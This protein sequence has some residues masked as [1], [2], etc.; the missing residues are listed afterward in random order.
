MQ[1]RSIKYQNKKQKTASQLK[2]RNKIYLFTKKSQ[3]KKVKQ[4]IELC[5]SRIVSCQED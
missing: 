5:Q 3:N 2:K 1:E 4:E